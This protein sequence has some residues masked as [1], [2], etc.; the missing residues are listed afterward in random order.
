VSELKQLEMMEQLM[1]EPGI[2]LVILGSE[3]IDND[4]QNH[5][6]KQDSRP[7]PQPLRQLNK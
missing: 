3:I 5:D 1:L 2:S 6:S 4:E 7:R